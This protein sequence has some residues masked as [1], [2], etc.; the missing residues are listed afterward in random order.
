ME[1]IPVYSASGRFEERV[2]ESKALVYERDYQATVVRKPCGKDKGA[3]VRVIHRARL[4]DGMIM[5]RIP[6]GSKFSYR[7]KLSSGHMVWRFRALGIVRGVGSVALAAQTR[8]A[9]A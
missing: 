4:S 6:S 9:H 1:L 5:L 7:E 3:I 8:V 2:T